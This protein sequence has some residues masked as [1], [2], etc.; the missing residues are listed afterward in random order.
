M[1]GIAKSTHPGGARA[2]CICGSRS[3]RPDRGVPPSFTRPS[4][5]KCR[6][7]WLGWLPTQGRRTVTGAI[8]AS[9]QLGEGTMRRGTASSRRRGGLPMNSPPVLQQI[10]AHFVAE[11][12]LVVVSL[13]DTL[14][15]KKG[16][17][18]WGIGN[19]IDA[20]RSSRG[21]KV[22][23]FGHVWV[24]LR[25]CSLRSA[26]AVGTPVPS[27]CTGAR[28][29]LRPTAWPASRRPNWP[30]SW[31]NLSPPGS[32]RDGS[33]ARRQ[34]LLLRRSRAEPA[35]QL[36]T[37]RC[38]AARRSPYD[39]A[40]SGACDGP[41]SPR[42]RG[43]RLPRPPRWSQDEGIRGSLRRSASTAATKS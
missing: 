23:C 37:G 17:R 42:L 3:D 22:F 6:Q 19:H 41:R 18:V 14:A 36:G 8:V 5:E 25:S 35:L 39:A 7:L 40:G 32:E 34:R 13:D 1:R 29:R 4:F 11:G 31:S 10:L 38:N 21:T 27:G 12:E 20:V 24:V 16:P 33:G 43:P 28:R 30:A 2:L 26:T 15:P 9:G